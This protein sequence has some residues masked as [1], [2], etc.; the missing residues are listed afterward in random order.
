MAV[1]SA[2]KN[3]KNQK[4]REGIEDLAIKFSSQDENETGV[5]LVDVISLKGRLCL[6][7]FSKMNLVV[8]AMEKMHVSFEE[9]EL[10][11]MMKVSDKNNKISKSAKSIS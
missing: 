7:L 1:F 3:K 10:G 2:I 11:R 6:N 9:K 8:A 4:F 5:H